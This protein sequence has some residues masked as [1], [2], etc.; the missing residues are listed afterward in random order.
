MSTF[1]LLRWIFRPWRLLWTPWTA[2]A[3]AIVLM[4]VVCVSL[5][6]ME[7]LNLRQARTVQ[8]QDAE[9]AV[10]N[11]TKA[12]GQHADD[13][14]LETDTLLLG[15]V[16]R[17]EVDGMELAVLE[18]LQRLLQRRTAALVSLDGIYIYDNT[19]R[20]IVNSQAVLPSQ[21]NNADREYFRFHQTDPSHDVHIGDPIQSRSTHHWIIPVSRRINYPDGSF[22]GVALATINMEYFTRFYGS[23]DVGRQGII[24]LARADATLMLRQ[25]FDAAVIGRNLSGSMIFNQLA[26]HDGPGT[27][28]M[29][30]SVDAVERLYS[31][32]RV[33]H[34]PL[35]VS[36]A[37][38]KQDI[39]ANWRH[40]AIRSASVIVVMVLLFSVIGG[41]L[42]WQIG[43][44]QRIEEELRQA[45]ASLE[46]MN[47]SLKILSLQDSLTGLGNRRQFDLSLANEFKRAMR[48]QTSLALI[49]IDVDY[50]KRYNDL[51]GH[52]AGDDCLRRISQAIQL[53]CH[54]AGDMAARYGG[55]EIAV[56]LSQTDVEGARSTAQRIHT[57]ITALAIPHAGNPAGRVTISA[58]FAAWIPV[59][60]T[61]TLLVQAADVALYAAKGNGRNRVCAYICPQ[62]PHQQT[63]GD[64][65]A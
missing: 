52:L 28:M 36:T 42:I 4:L 27:I 43:T 13:T 49:M 63:P 57:A 24:F 44:R 33:A 61:E 30:S 3:L 35:V 17:L 31:Y 9:R 12:L 5:I 2:R 53:A 55:E 46:A 65:L 29:V 59:E 6:G 20:W 22:A 32:R 14:I 34:Y 40:A 60:G 50:F 26:A 23:F 10:S 21:A 1:S 54:R 56:L 48:N 47:Q 64:P 45:T 16:E 39:L 41:R 18:R 38:S 37:L 11:M 62:V 15:L 58:G 25:P 7:V 8:L 51:Y 19:G